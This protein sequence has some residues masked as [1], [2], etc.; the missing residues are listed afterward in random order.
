MKYSIRY[1]QEDVEWLQYTTQNMSMDRCIQVIEYLESL[2]I[3]VNYTYSK[4]GHTFSLTT[5]YNHSPTPKRVSLTEY[6]KEALIQNL[7]DC[8]L[9]LN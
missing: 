2:G 7:K 8:N 4:K 6:E 5:L 1:V 3:R 9:V